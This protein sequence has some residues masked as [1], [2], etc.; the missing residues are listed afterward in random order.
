MLTF[1]FLILTFRSSSVIPQFIDSFI[2][3]ILPSIKKGESEVIFVDNMS[4]D[5]TFTVTKEHL[6]KYRDL[7]SEEGKSAKPIKVIQNTENAGYAKGI[8]FAATFA[9][10]EIL[11]IVNPDAE[12]KSHD[13]EKIRDAFDEEEKLAI[14]GLRLETYEKTTERTAGKFYNPF[15]FLIYALGLEDTFSLRYAPQKAEKVD[16]VSGGFLAIRRESFEKLKGY[17]TDYFMYVEDMDLCYRAKKAGFITMYLPYATIKHRGQGSSS[18]EFAI[19]NIYKGMQTFYRKHSSGIFQWYVG[20]L[21]AVKAVSIIFIATIIGKR[22]LAQTY[23]K[24]LQ[25]LA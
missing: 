20:C 7:V 3:D 1:S 8:N 21:L 22:E 10:G 15:T 5:D 18:K 16:F 9:N 6:A 2:D 19:V 25:T 24:A 4:P 23:Q 13:F 17:D 12:L 14:A 11:V